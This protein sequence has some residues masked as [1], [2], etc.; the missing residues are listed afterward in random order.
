M[1]EDPSLSGFGYTHCLIISS[2]L[3]WTMYYSSAN[4]SSTR[5]ISAPSFSSHHPC[6]G[7][8]NVWQN[9]PVAQTFGLLFTPLPVVMPSVHVSLSTNTS[10]RSLYLSSFSLVSFSLGP[11]SYI[12]LE[13]KRRFSGKYLTTQWWLPGG[14]ANRVSLSFSFCTE[15]LVPQG[16]LICQKQHAL[17]GQ[18]LP[19][20]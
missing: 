17:L 12:L 11:F 6:T 5:S 7:I 9:N 20:G 14:T 15:W 4:P 16:P 18:R 3:T 2:P 8:G 10:L 1:P 13:R 19:L